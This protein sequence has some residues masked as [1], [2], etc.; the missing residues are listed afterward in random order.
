M[1]KLIG[2]PELKQA[3]DNLNKSI[4]HDHD[5]I[6]VWDCVEN[7][8]CSGSFKKQKVIDKLQ[9]KLEGLKTENA[10]RRQQQR[11]GLKWIN[12]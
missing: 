3:V 7:C 8:V 4:K 11:E 2:E 9:L 12:F 10:L 5:Y 1:P 6:S